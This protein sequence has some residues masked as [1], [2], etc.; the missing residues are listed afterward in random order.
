MEAA[1]DLEELPLVST[2]VLIP[3]KLIFDFDGFDS[4]KHAGN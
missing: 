4:N 2:V 1:S 3:S